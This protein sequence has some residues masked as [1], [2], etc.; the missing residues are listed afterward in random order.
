MT[1]EMGQ[2]AGALSRA[3]GL[4]AEARADFTAMSST[5]SA[6]ISGLQGRWV[7]AGAASFMTLH[8]TWSEQQ[9]K[10]VQ[11]LEEFD[12]ALRATEQRNMSTDED[13][14]AKYSNLTSRLG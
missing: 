4:V 3:A 8:Q 6:Q 2:G 10:I 11:A 14:A 5:L 9:A 7:G 1:N 12:S 13:Q